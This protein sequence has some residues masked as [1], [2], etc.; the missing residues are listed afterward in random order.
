M[1]AILH[2]DMDAFYASVEQRDNPSLRGKPVI[3]GGHAQRGVVVA[4]S[5]EVRPFGVRSAMPMARAMKQAPHAIVVK[6]RFSAYAEA[7]EHVFAIFERYTPLIEPLSLDEAFL[8]VT[9]SVG[10]F[11]AAADIAKRIRKEIAHELNLPASAGIATAKFVAKIASDL[12]KPNGQ[13]E[14]RPEETVAFLAGLPVSRLWGVGPKTEEAMKRA[15]LVTIG[16]VAARDVDWLEERFGA[17]SAKHLWEL[18]HGI[19]ARDVVPDRAAKSVGAEDTFDEDLTGLEAL[20][21][22]VHAQALRVARRL[23]RATLKGRVVQLKLKFADFTL[24]TRRVTLREATDD[25]QVIY[26]AALEL[27]ERAHEGKALRLTGVSV[28]LDED[29]PQLGLFPAAAPKSS[30]L[31]EAMDRI[32]ARFGSKAITMADI[33]GAEAS[34]DDQHR[35]EKPVDKPKR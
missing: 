30:K 8:D 4:A 22:H 32:A 34:D 15:G 18:S 9:A 19:D 5:Y 31:N 21:P 33:A 29:E 1:R 23:R 25:G 20:K 7:S 6:P 24:I 27:L 10:L 14:V 17:A 2:V 16:D 28:Q 35:S 12:A 13:R 26:R 3:V 11:G